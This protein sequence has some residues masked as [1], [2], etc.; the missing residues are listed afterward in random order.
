MNELSCPFIDLFTRYRA[1]KS[2]NHWIIQ[3]AIVLSAVVFVTPQL[4][5]SKPSA[6]VWTIGYLSAGPGLDGDWKPFLDG[7]QALGYVDGKN[8]RIERRFANNSRSDLEKFAKELVDLRVAVI[9]AGDSTSIRPA[10][11]AT[12][13]IPIV[14]TISGDPV[15][16]GFVTSLARPGGNVTGLAN[17]QNDLISKRVQLLGET[18]VHFSSVAVLGPPLFGEGLKAAAAAA[19][20]S[21]VKLQLLNVYAPGEFEAAFKKATE[22]QVNGLIVVPSPLTNRNMNLLVR[23]AADH[24]IPVMYPRRHYSQ[25]G[26]LMAYGPSPQDWNRRA[27]S[28]VDRILKG[29]KPADLPVEQPSKF[30]FVIN[31]KTAKSL[32]ITIPKSLLIIADEVID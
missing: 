29:A 24:R 13:T 16:D 12:K 2:M 11:S 5:H 8:I 4:V 6:K 26:G 23:L 30:E 27:A 31:R 14:M 19:N 21:G 7:L 3:F 9:V 18:L 17:M 22:L 25:I 20:A 28:Y 1:G 32:G 15:A 10:M